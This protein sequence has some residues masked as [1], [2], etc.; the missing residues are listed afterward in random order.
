MAYL[1]I[2]KNRHQLNETGYI[3]AKTNEAAYEI[4]NRTQVNYR[5]R[6][7]SLESAFSSQDLLMLT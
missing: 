7:K 1:N 6:I 2:D 5:F 3:H 4:I